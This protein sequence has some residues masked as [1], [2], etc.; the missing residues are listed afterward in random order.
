MVNNR[1]D[2]GLITSLIMLLAGIGILT[3]LLGGFDT[4]ILG[5]KIAFFVAAY[6]ICG[7]FVYRIVLELL[8]R[9]RG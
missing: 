2:A 4:F 9:Y 1:A 7:I 5:I 3:H 8:D 6:C